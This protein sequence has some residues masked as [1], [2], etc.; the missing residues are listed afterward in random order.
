[1]SETLYVYVCVRVCVCVLTGA[2]VVHQ[3]T[4]V[5]KRGT[6]GGTC[7]NVG[8]IPSKALLHSSHL[9]EE[10]NHTF[11]THGINV[12]NVT[13]DLPQ[14]MMKK[15][16]SVGGLTKGVEGA[17]FARGLLRDRP[18]ECSEGETG[19]LKKWE[20]SS[21]TDGIACA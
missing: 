13:V 9:F 11:K 16:S 4:C 17:S 3:T 15:T 12:E 2:G 14:M 21:P 7:L 19:G 1:M 10:A 6:L 18:Q 20:G 5:E 8:C